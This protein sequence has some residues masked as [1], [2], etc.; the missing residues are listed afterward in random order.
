MRSTPNMESIRLTLRRR[1][2]PG[3]FILQTHVLIGVFAMGTAWPKCDSVRRTILEK[4][5][6]LLRQTRR[7]RT[8]HDRESRPKLPY[9]VRSSWDYVDPWG[10]PTKSR[11]TAITIVQIG[12]ALNYDISYSHDP[13]PGG[14]TAVQEGDWGQSYGRVTNGTKTPL[15]S[16]K[17]S[18]DVISWQ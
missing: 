15:F 2:A 5:S 13:P 11:L 1:T 4:S 10:T 18:D 7:I 6:L 17:G 3:R 16:F 9:G 8:I 14:A 12:T